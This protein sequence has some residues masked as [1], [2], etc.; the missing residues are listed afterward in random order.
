MYLGA[1][2]IAYISYGVTQ[3]VFAYILI[4]VIYTMVI[5]IL[6]AV[7]PY[8]SSVHNIFD[9][10][11]LVFLVLFGVF[12]ASGTL[13]YADLPTQF[14]KATN[15]INFILYCVPLVYMSGTLIY[16]MVVTRR[17]P[18]QV[19]QWCRPNRHECAELEASLA[20]RMIHPEQYERL[21]PDPVSDK[22]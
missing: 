3:N 5:I 9:P 13:A 6:I 22:D 17:I 21:L 19:A 15:G 2:L 11:V 14:L 8:S 16:W 20:D 10:V 4:I 7:Q 12:A 18:Q 1:R